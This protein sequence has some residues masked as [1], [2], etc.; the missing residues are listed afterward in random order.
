MRIT[1]Q[2][3]NI[4]DFTKV[5][6]YCVDNSYIH[7]A[8]IIWNYTSITVD[9]NDIVKVVNFYFSKFDFEVI[10]DINKTIEDVFMAKRPLQVQSN[11]DL[12]TICRNCFVEFS[13]LT[14][15]QVCQF[16]GWI[17]CSNCCKPIKLYNYNAN[18]IE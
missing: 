13:I 16:C 4:H 10:P 17:Y 2:Y 7:L 9:K 6:K 11:L 15:I 1:L 14:N 3:Y 18:I 5:L 12:E 8:F